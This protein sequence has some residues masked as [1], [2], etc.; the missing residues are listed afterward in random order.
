MR[1][2]KQGRKLNR[3]PAHRRAL[4]RNQAV[5]LLRHESM[6]TTLPKAKQ[7]R[8]VVE[9]LITLAKKGNLHARRLAYQQVRDKQVLHKLFDQ[10]ASR[11]QQRPGGYTRVMKSGFRRGDNAM[12]AV[13]ELLPAQE[14]EKQE[15]SNESKNSPEAQSA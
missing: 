7:L 15:K 12:R 8:G 3:T 5:S 6:Q 11:F 2:L 14:G 9:R 1:H 10:L 13:I 4:W